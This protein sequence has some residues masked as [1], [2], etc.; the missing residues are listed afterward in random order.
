MKCLTTQI[1]CDYSFKYIKS[2]AIVLS[3][4]FNSCSEDFW[5]F[6]WNILVKKICMNYAK[7][8]CKIVYLAQF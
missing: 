6:I 7:V 3:F 4:S 1:T 2:E 8:A 5:K